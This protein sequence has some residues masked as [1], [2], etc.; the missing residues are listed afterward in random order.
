MKTGPGPTLYTGTSSLPCQSSFATCPPIDLNISSPSLPD[1]GN[2]GITGTS[3]P[4]STTASE[5]LSQSSVLG[6]PG[7]VGIP[8]PSINSTHLDPTW[9]HPPVVREPPR[10]AA[11]VLTISVNQHPYGPSLIRVPYNIASVYLSEPR[12]DDRA[13]DGHAD[14]PQRGVVLQAAVVD[15][16]SRSDDGAGLGVGV[17][18]RE[19]FVRHVGVRVAVVDFLAQL[20]LDGGLRRRSGQLQGP[21]NGVTQRDSV[22]GYV[23]GNVGGGENGEGVA[24]SGLATDPATWGR[25]VIVWRCWDMEALSN[26]EV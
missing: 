16:D 25:R 11:V 24:A 4:S 18:R 21:R 7:V 12:Q 6:R 14:L 2:E 3:P 22:G 15:V 8:K 13:I 23:G 10:S 26:S 9:G 5:S 1:T 17:E 20:E 19:D